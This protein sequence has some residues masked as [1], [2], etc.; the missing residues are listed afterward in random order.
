MPVP[1]DLWMLSWIKLENRV[2]A[3]AHLTGKTDCIADGCSEALQAWKCAFLR[4]LF[5]KCLQNTLAKLFQEFCTI[6][7]IPCNTVEM[8]MN[9]RQGNL[10]S[11]FG[12]ATVFLNAL[13]DSISATI[14]HFRYLK[15]FLWK[16]KENT[17]K[18]LAKRAQVRIIGTKQKWQLF[19]LKY[20]N[21]NFFTIKRQLSQV[22][23]HYC[24]SCH[25]TYDLIK[26]NK[27]IK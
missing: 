19:L 25:H 4:A 23:L 5:E 15:T 26:L 10:D 24:Y 1:L 22:W 7:G 20:Y 8:A 3:M 12:S 6:L 9:L 16:L 14:N 18:Y 27:N 13:R 11:S 21:I 2:P 17:V